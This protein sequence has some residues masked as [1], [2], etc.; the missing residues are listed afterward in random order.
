M[1]AYT[2]CLLASLVYGALRSAREGR[3]QGG[4]IDFLRDVKTEFANKGCYREGED[5]GA[6]E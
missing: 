4:I 2:L 5:S 3:G 6:G 1:V